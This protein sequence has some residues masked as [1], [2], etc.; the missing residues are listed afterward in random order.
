[1]LKLYWT[2]W[3]FIALTALLLVATGNFTPLT[4]VAFGFVSFGM[5]FM[6]MINVLPTVVGPHAAPVEPK[7]PKVKPVK[8]KAEREDRIFQPK[9]L[10][11][12]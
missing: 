1:M 10:A 2:L 9:P 8:T 3:A 7:Q 11:T 12:R 5:I 6:G 4:L